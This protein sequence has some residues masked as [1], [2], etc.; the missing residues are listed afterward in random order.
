MSAAHP[1]ELE[2]HPIE[3]RHGSLPLVADCGN[4]CPCR[5]TVPP[6]LWPAPASCLLPLRL[7][8]WTEGRQGHFT[9]GRGDSCNGRRPTKGGEDARQNPYSSAAFELPLSLV[10]AGITMHTC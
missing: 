7:S 5:G 3:C 10:W 9:S 6:S 8:S 1:L 2:P 4:S